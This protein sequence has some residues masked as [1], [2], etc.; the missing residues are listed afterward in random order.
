M[1]NEAFSIVRI[2]KKKFPRRIQMFNTSGIAD[3]EKEVL[4]KSHMATVL[5]APGWK[6]V[7]VLGV[8][9]NEYKDIFEYYGY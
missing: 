8:S 5:Y 1:T 2:L 4:Y 7:E 6:Y 3:D 9:E